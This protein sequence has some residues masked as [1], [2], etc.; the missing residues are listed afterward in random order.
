MKPLCQ[1]EHKIDDTQLFPSMLKKQT[2][3]SLEEEYV[4]YDVEFCSQM[5]SLMRQFPTS[6]MKFTRRISYP[7]YLVK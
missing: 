5:Y 6:L 7:K 4:S 3:L 2:P 1:N